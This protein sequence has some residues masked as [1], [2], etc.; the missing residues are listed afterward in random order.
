MGG[1]IGVQSGKRALAVRHVFLI[2]VAFKKLANRLRAGITAI[3]SGRS[4]AVP[5]IA[6]SGFARVTIRAPAA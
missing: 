6:S 5:T 4:S 1:D 3:R 2:G